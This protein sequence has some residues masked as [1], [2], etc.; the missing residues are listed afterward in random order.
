MEKTIETQ[1][2][3]IGGGA[4]GTG[5]AR[6]L[7]LRGVRVILIEKSDLNAGASG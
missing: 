2:L 7:S 4:T 3:V 5:I 1:V 6:D